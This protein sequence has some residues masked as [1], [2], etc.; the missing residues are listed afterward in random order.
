M[1]PANFL[2]MGRGDQKYH[3]R[4]EENK[5]SLLMDLSFTLERMDLLSLTEKSNLQY[6][7]KYCQEQMEADRIQKR[8]E[9]YHRRLG[10]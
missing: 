3:I 4:T 5:K 10:Y 7:I 9:A 2:Q 1:L 8:D 6:C